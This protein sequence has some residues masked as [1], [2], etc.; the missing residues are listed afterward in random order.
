VRYSE[1]KR[2]KNTSLETSQEEILV[3]M[4]KKTPGKEEKRNLVPTFSIMTKSEVFMDRVDEK[5]LS[6]VSTNYKF[7]RPTI[8]K[9]LKFTKG[10]SIQSIRNCRASKMQAVVHN[11]IF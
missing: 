4:F 1:H 2:P 10:G 9:T 6:A 3:Q 11:W 5:I 8:M 7:M